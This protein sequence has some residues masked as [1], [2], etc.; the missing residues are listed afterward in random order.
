MLRKLRYR[1][2]GIASLALCVLL[3]VQVIA[4]NLANIYQRDSDTKKIL[5]QLT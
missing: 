3:L 4:V 1:F 2:V 5:T